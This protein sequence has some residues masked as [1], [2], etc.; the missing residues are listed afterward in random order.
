MEDYAYVIEFLPSGRASQL[1]KEP[2][3]QL[4]GMKFFTLLEATA[5]AGVNISIG[6]KIFVGRDGRSE[7]EKIRG[8]ITFSDLSS[9]VKDFLQSS[10]RKVI[11]DR[12]ADF[13][14]FINNSKSISIRVHTLDLLPGIGKKNMEAILEERSKK[15]FDNF[16]DLKARV[17][18]LSDPIGIFVHRI[19]NEMDGKEKY[20]LFTKPPFHV[21]QRSYRY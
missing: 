21:E 14:A 4:V 1:R 7:I 10:L 16:A 11:E 12:E 18:T 20:Y 13:I 9:S 17:S 5:K 19:I 3:V 15:P 6:Q 8:R 2:I